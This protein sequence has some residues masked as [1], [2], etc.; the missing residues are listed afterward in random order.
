MLR[1]AACSVYGMLPPDGTGAQVK[2]DK[3][4]DATFASYVVEAKITQ[5]VAG[6]LWQA[7]LPPQQGSASTFTVSNRIQQSMTLAML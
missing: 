1:H 5:G 7:C 3:S 4:S 6:A 2:L